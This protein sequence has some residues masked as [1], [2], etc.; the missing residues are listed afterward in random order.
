[1][2][3]YA[4]SLFCCEF[5]SSNEFLKRSI[6]FGFNSFTFFLPSYFSFLIGSTQCFVG[7]NHQSGKAIQ[8][9]CGIHTFFGASVLYL[10]RALE[11]MY[12]KLKKYGEYYVVSF[13][14]NFS[15]VL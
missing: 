1:M 11:T 14:W 4:A 6:F 3:I 15:N 9:L 13:F 5:F 12:L 7:K 8:G 10:C 2:S